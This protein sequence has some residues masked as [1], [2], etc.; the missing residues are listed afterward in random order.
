MFID[1]MKVDN[2]AGKLKLEPI[3]F[4]FSRFKCWVRNQDNSWR[5]WAYM[6]EVKQLIC[7]SAEVAVITPK[8]HLQEYHDILGFFMKDLQRLQQKGIK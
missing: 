5:T 7:T 2:L 8:Q 3:T 4:T 1:A 6:E